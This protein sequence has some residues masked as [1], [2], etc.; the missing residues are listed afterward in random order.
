MNKAKGKAINFHTVN[1][2][3]TSG[4]GTAA[5]PSRHAQKPAEVTI[6]VMSG[7]QQNPYMIHSS[8]CTIHTSIPCDPHG[9]AQSGSGHA[10]AHKVGSWAMQKVEVEHMV[11]ELP[12]NR[13]W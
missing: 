2:V 11:S 13:P 4:N 7:R 12:D 6:A 10:V 1:S 9:P 3:Q 8:G 5:V